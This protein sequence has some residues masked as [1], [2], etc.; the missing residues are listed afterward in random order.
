MNETI[1]QNRAKEAFELLKKIEQEKK[2]NKFQKE[3]KSLAK[4][5]P[6]LIMDNSLMA[7]LAFWQA[8]SQAKNDAGKLLVYAILKWLK[9]RKIVQSLNFTEAMQNL[10]EKKAADYMYATKETLDY[11]KWLR[12]LVPTILDTGEGE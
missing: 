5:A 9:E 7:S 4:G 1:E 12:N 2:T 8:K 3:F 11:L 6:A 10:Y